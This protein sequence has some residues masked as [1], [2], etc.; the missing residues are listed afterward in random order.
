M[1]SKR[2][3]LSRA[4]AVALSL[5]ALTANSAFSYVDLAPTLSKIIGDSKRIAVVEVVAFDRSHGLLTLKEVSSLKGELSSQPIRQQVA[6]TGGGAVPRQISQ[7]VEPGARGVA[8]V[9]RRTMLICVGQGWYPVRLAEG[10]VWKLGADRPDLPLAY[11]GTTSRLI[12][13]VRKML[14][15]EDAVLTAVSYGS[16]DVD[17]SIDLALHRTDLPGLIKVERFRANLKMPPMVAG[18]SAN[19]AYFLGQGPA[20]TSDIPQLVRQLQSSDATVRVEAATDLGWLEKKASEA[21]PAL[22]Q[23]L[24][25][26]APRA[27]F[28]AAVALLRISPTDSRG[29]RVLASG[30][31][32]TDPAIKR[33]AV[34]A[35]G[36][37]GPQGA[38]LVQSLSQALMDSDSSVRLAALEAI[39]TLGPAAASAKDNV[40]SLLDQPEFAVDAADALGRIGPAA[41]PAP[42]QLSKM[43]KSDQASSRWAAVRALSQI[44]GPESHP[45][46]AFMIRQFPKAGEVDAYNMLV[47]LAILGPD[48][49]DAAPTVRAL[50]VRLNPMLR[51]A[52][53]WAIDPENRF[54]WQIGGEFGMPGRMPRGGMGG[55]PDGD[56]P[57]LGAYI[58]CAYFHELGDRLRPVVRKLSE[59]IIAG[60]AGEIP[61]WGYEL[62]NCAPDEALEILTPNLAD[63]GGVKCERAA[64]ALGYMG[65]AAAK[66]KPQ[67][68]AAIARST[69]EQQRRLLEWTARQTSAD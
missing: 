46:V 8:F 48:A 68:D 35:I 21:V 5:A 2:Q 18:A 7:W 32:S 14:A 19:R 29:I 26:S 55:P 65:P 37:A 56:G 24:G 9:S 39:A 36:M 69:D 51:P 45:A 20:D 15:G 42:I 62:L 23:M 38:K 22:G 30:V 31:E 57:D 43:L 17:T 63:Q 33:D 16:K 25:D 13:G 41:R 67:I 47:Y 49:K 60:T 61:S 11:Y 52:T 28:A 64:V 66:A 58:Y 34:Q 27:R 10:N 50:R 12:E 3:I 6:A 54:P 4:F 44:G 59:Q 1:L 40:A 53:E